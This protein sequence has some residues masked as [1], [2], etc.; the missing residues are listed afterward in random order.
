MRPLPTRVFVRAMNA[1]AGPPNASPCSPSAR[2]RA[3]ATVLLALLVMLPRPGAGQ[4]ARVRVEIEG[5]GG[6]LRENALSA[7]SLNAA[8]R[9]GE[10]AVDRIRRLHARAPG[11][12]AN[13]LQAYGYYRPHID[14]AI[15]Q[16][17]TRWV[18]RYTV[19]QGAPLLVSG[20]DL[21]LRGA[22]AE[23]RRLRQVA[24]QFPLAVGSIL[25]HAAYESGKSALLSR[26]ADLGFLDATFE[27]SEIRID[28]DSYSAQIVL[29]FETGSRFAFGPVTF[30]QDV[31]EPAVLE[32][33]VPFRRG[34]P[35]SISR[36]LELQ[37]RLSASP[38]FDRVEVQPRR[39]LA[40][41]L[42]VPVDV[43][44]VPRK[45]QRFEVGA[46]YGTDTGLRGTLEATLRRVN[47]RG[48]QAQ[49]RLNLSRVEQSI[50]ARY[51]MPSLYPRTDVVTLSAGFA[52]LHTATSESE[53][54][55]L[56]ASIARSRGAWDE[57]LSLDLSRESYEV[58]ADTG[59]AHLLMPGGNWSRTD[60]DDRIFTNRGYR[61]RFHVRG[62]HDALLSDVSFVQL[63]ASGKLIRSI[64]ERVRFIARADLGVIF[65]SDFR[66][67]PPTIRF[68]AGGD[69]SVRGFAYRSLGRR[70]EVGE[71]VGGEV[72]EVASAELE[73]RFLERWG[74]AG[75]Y[76]V[77]D[78]LDSFSLS[79][80][81]GAGLG[82]RWLSP[83]GLVRVDG[84]L[85]VS[86]SGTPFR[87]H[88]TVGPDL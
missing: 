66:R 17:G 40:E 25:E 26:A 52:R 29:H 15:R 47:R 32:G 16:E 11:E 44:M 67:L 1:R 54:V 62:S 2:V 5:I 76:D 68:F 21:Q 55:L 24:S 65:A 64:W 86:R 42:E 43:D 18:A 35:F 83:I 4:V 77:G 19:D 56:G 20:L 27:R 73:Y 81:Q 22:G 36:L 87:L 38:Y 71:M 70:D 46:G 14:A 82:L 60:A 41:G 63:R 85:A 79:L 39:D 10:L 23:D 72:L 69:Q 45:P 31:V 53:Q 33:Y 7:L 88:L 48:H 84:A 58:G 74:L 75:F 34:E 80:E 9:E 13:A 49:A 12:I 51:L 8:A 3:V 57:T 50:A 61:L 59:V 28:L 30:Q 6:R 37:A 78:A